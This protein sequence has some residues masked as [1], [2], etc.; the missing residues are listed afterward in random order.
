MLVDYFQ[1]DIN[2]RRVSE[3]TFGPYRLQ[4]AQCCRFPVAGETQRQQQ[5]EL[6]HGRCT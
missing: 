1:I 5:H 2:S 3:T 6:F 4:K